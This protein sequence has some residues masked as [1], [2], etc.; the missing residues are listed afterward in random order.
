M[1]VKEA[2][3]VEEDDNMALCPPSKVAYEGVSE[4]AHIAVCQMIVD[5]GMQEGTYGLKPQVY[6]RFEVPGERVS[7]T[8]DQGVESEGPRVIG[9]GYG[10]TLGPKATL[11]KHLE[12]WRG[13]AFTEAELMDSEGNPIWDI[14]KLLGVPCQLSVVKNENGTSVISTIMGLPKGFPPPKAEG[15]LI[16]Y[17][18]DNTGSLIKLPPWMQDKIKTAG[19]KSDSHN[20]VDQSPPPHTMQQAQPASPPVADFDDDIPF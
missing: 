17:D 9:K 18:S 20:H 6:I 14:T 5:M 11:R 16:V 12:S 15:D 2:L 19:Q 1:K 3:W 4:G 13:R 7:Y 10:Y 8:N